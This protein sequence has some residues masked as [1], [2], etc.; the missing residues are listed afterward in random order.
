M[1]CQRTVRNENCS[2]FERLVK[3]FSHDKRIPVKF[4]K[5][6][7]K[8]SAEDFWGVCKNKTKHDGTRFISEALRD[9]IETQ[10]TLVMNPFVHYDLNKPT[11]RTELETTIDLVKQ[12]K[13]ALA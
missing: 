3:N 13:T 11:F 7:S 12:L 1:S 8:M 4:N 9:N 6:Q 10:R 5:N 2:K